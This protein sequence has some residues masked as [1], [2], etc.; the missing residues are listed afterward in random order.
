MRPLMFAGATLLAAA[1]LS[2]SAAELAVDAPATDVTVYADG[3][4]VH[5][6][7]SVQL[8]EGS[9][10][11]KVRG[12]GASMVEQSL[13]V[14]GTGHMQIQSIEVRRMPRTEMNKDAV[15]ALSAKA[16]DARSRAQMAAADLA[17]LEKRKLFLEG[18]IDSASKMTA[19]TF[20]A[21]SLHQTLDTIEHDYAA[22]G[23]ALVT[24]KAQVDTLQDAQRKAESDLAQAQQRQ[25]DLYEVR[26]SVEVGQAG[27]AG[28]DLA[29]RVPDASW[30]AVYDMRLEFG[31]R[32]AHG[33]P[34]RR[35]DPGYRR[36]LEPCRPHTDHGALGRGR[37]SYRADGGPYRA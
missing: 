23:H 35:R 15:A 30:A 10:V 21:Q 3:A 17:A 37:C 34:G 4:I 33:E 19:Q 9:H 27:P 32:Q 28:I 25:R 7:G 12:I 11:L 6:Q 2:A 16:A 36:G 22:N 8:P 24:Q 13:R 5:R 18:V 31:G 20:S 14:S 1:A 29:Y 26:V